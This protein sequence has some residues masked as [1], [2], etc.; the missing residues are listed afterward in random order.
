MIL[1][2]IFWLAVIYIIIVVLWR[3][4]VAVMSIIGGYAE[5]GFWGALGMAAVNLL[6]NVWDLAKFAFTILLLVF[7]LKTCSK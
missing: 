2:I 6:I 4:F 7:V 3:L 1:Q 5:H